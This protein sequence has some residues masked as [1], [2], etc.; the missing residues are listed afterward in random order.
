MT[1]EPW[2]RTP[3]G[4]TLRWVTGEEDTGGAYAL[5][6]R[7]A[8]PGARSPGHQHRRSEAFYMI[9]G[10]MTY[11]IAGQTMRV[12][13]GS[14]V[15]AA[16]RVPHGWEVTGDRPG[17]VL[18]IFAPSAPRAYFAEIDAIVRGAREGQLDTSA[19]ASALERYGWT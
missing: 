2:Y 8:P 19:L 17:R 16:D 1:D 6:E 14:Y 13:P 7:V 18:L 11:T 9:D 5:L 4:D 10:E 3:F 15:C 12:S